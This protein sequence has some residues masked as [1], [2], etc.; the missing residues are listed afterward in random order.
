MFIRTIFSLVVSFNAFCETNQQT[1]TAKATRSI[2]DIANGVITIHAVH[3]DSFTCTEHW[4]GQFD[5]LGD[6]LGSDCVIQGW[7]QDDKRLFMRPYFNQGFKNEEWLGFNKDVLAPCDCTVEE[8]HINPI[9]NEPGIMTPGQASSITFKTKGGHS[10]LLAHVQSI[11]VKEGDRLK[12]GSVV[13]KVGNNGYSR[14][15]HI[16]IGAWSINEKPLQIRFDQQTLNLTMR[17]Y[18]KQRDKNQL[19]KKTGDKRKDNNKE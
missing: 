2:A 9:T 12:A 18:T 16:H 13:A 8:I 4:T 11:N 10:V 17:E 5:Y 14:N 19:D 7:Y 15:P 1:E 6:A 3:K